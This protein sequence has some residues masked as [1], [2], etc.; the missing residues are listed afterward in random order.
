M[1]HV[2]PEIL[3][4]KRKVARGKSPSKLWTSPPR[5]PTKSKAT[6]KK[7]KKKA[8][9]S[10][11]SHKKVSFERPRSPTDDNGDGTRLASEEPLNLSTPFV[12][13]I[14]VD[15]GSQS[16]DVDFDRTP[17]ATALTPQ[18]QREHRFRFQRQRALKSVG[19]FNLKL[20]QQRVAERKY[21]YDL[22]TNVS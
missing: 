18:Q 10:A 16:A 22:Q 13:Q 1:E 21:Y 4:P 11:T 17:S 7:S 19:K 12:S 14:S 6:L 8:L 9:A 5:R 20:N 2:S 15:S 3:S